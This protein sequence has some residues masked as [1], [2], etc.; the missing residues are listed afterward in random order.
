VLEVGTK[1]KSIRFFDEDH[2]VSDKVVGGTTGRKA[3]FVK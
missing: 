1:V 2:E 3:W